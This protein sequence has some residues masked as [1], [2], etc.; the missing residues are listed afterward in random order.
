MLDG[1]YV[2]YTDFDNGYGKNF[3]VYKRYI[4]DITPTQWG[5][6]QSSTGGP[7]DGMKYPHFEPRDR[8]GFFAELLDK[9][10]LPEEWIDFD[11]TCDYVVGY[12][13]QGM[14]PAEMGNR[15]CSIDDPKN[16][17]VNIHLDMTL[18]MWAGSNDDVVKVLS[19]PI[20]LLDAA[21]KGMRAAKEAGSEQ[22]DKGFPERARVL[23]QL[24]DMVIPTIVGAI[25]FVVPFVGKTSAVVVGASTVA[26]MIALIGETV[27]MAYGVYTV[28][29]D[30]ELALM[31]LAGML[32][33]A[34]G[35]ARAARNAKGFRE[36]GARRVQM[37]AGG[38]AAKLG[39]FS[40]NEDG[41]RD[42]VASCFKWWKD[43]QGN[44]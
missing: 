24:S 41:L 43:V 26:R 9:S 39:G 13:G 35:L 5:F 1:L 3:D 4:D 33:G 7:G 16:S 11:S 36:M 17:L 12:S 32:T 6:M 31:S 15:H 34:G 19:V 21:V 14:C 18:G 42:I 8:D 37:H 30:P 28:V 23:T 2:E 22:E 27:I 38:S 10:G 44:S 20:F 40:E 25:L 29:G